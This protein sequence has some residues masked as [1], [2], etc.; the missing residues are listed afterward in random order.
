MRF[1]TYDNNSNKLDRSTQWIN[2]KYKQIFSNKIKYNTY[3]QIIKRY[4]PADKSYDYFIAFMPEKDKDNNRCRID[5]LGRCK[6]SISEIW[7]DFCPNITKD[8]NVNLDYI[9]T[10][11][12]A[13]IFKLSY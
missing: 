4:V 10:I 5:E 1:A 11:N 9:E 3:Y 7:N 8:T 6:F 12:G 13:D 2:V